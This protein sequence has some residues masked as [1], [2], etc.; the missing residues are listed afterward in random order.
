[1]AELQ[2]I[3]CHH[4]GADL[5]GRIALP[6]GEGPHPC[7]LVMHDALGLGDLV[8]GRAARLA[9]EGYVAVTT[10]MYGGGIRCQEAHAAG[11]HMAQ[12]IENPEK[13]RRRAVTWFDALRGH[14]AVDRER[15]GAIGFCFGG[16][17]ALEL[18]RSGAD[19]K[20][21]VSF[22]GLLTTFSPAQPK[23][24]KG[25]VAVYAGDRD[26]YAPEEHVEAF[27]SEMTAA[28]A[29]WQV[30]VFHDVFHG[31]TDPDIES[32]TG[33]EGI[34]YDPLADEVSWSGTLGLLRATIG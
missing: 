21:V 7:V 31:F 13:L 20:A 17:C 12:F 30:T 10:D 6:R 26:P 29:R 5:E 28:G 19:V 23:S 9:S 3:H 33:V 16:Q 22:H 2:P 8:R 27:R 34:R 32:L 25:V 4:A 1:V 18:A 24:V 14:P 15:I 11:V